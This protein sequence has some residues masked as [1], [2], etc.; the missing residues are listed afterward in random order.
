MSG[1]E[2]MPMVMGAISAA[3]AVMKMVAAKKAAAKADKEM[4]ANRKMI[5]EDRATVGAMGEGELSS[6]FADKTNTGL[7]GIGGDSTGLGGVGAAPGLTQPPPSPLTPQLG[8]AQRPKS[9]TLSGFN[10]GGR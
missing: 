4:E 6:A 1:A 2:A 10:F 7:A 8:S 9:N 5:E 3:M